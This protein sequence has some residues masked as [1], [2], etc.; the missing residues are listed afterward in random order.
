MNRSADHLAVGA[1]E[2]RCLN[3]DRELDG[4]FCSDCGQARSQGLLPLRAWLAQAL[5]SFF[6]LDFRILRTAWPLFVRPGFLTLEYVGGRRVRYTN[7]LR[8]YIVV[9]ALSIAAMSVSGFLNYD[10]MVGDQLGA[11]LGISEIA[12]PAYRAAFDRR[13]NAVFPVVNLLSPLLLGILLKLVYWR[14]L[15]E[16]HLVFGLHF[17]S[18]LVLA[19][20]LFLPGYGLGPEIGQMLALALWL[21][22]FVYLGVAAWRVYGGAGWKLVLRLPV[23]IVGLVTMTQAVAVLAVFVVVALS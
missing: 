19:G 10:T 18:F 5:D 12:D 7:P 8:L 3:C 20:L 17:F 6:G 2:D 16:L 4:A 15:F 11:A 14:S 22:F 13:L 1:G 21:V 9:S 23:L